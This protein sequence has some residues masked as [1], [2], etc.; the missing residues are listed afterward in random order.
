MNPRRIDYYD[1]PKAPQ[2]NSLV[3]SVNVVVANNA[4]EILLIRRTDNELGHT[5]RRGRPR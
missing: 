1:D 4:G 2:A 3:P 5:R